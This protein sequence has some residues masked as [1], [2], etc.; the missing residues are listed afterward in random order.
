MSPVRCW[1]H[2][3]LKF[4]EVS[5]SPTARQVVKLIKGMYAVEKAAAYLT[6]EQRETMRQERSLP[7]ICEIEDLLRRSEAAVE[8]KVKSAINYALNAMDDLARFI[9]DGRLEID[10]NPVE[11]CIR[12]IVLTRKN[13]LFAGSFESAE[14][15]A[16]YFT[17]I[18]TAKLNGVDPRAYLQWAANEI[19][20]NKGNV[21][22]AM[23][24]PWHFPVGRDGV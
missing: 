21:D 16:I 2:A 3:R 20:H 14:T 19:E 6:F 17:L 18:E 10:N 11:R 5:G 22:Y 15:W 13:S 1:A 9:F 12:G 4:E 8:G 24:M 23:L 7:I